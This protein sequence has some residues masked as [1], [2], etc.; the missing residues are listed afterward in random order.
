MEEGAMA[1]ELLP[2]ALWARIAPLLPPEPPKPKGGRPR[3][4]DRVA[5][6][7]ILFVLKT[8][9]PW[10]YLPAEM[11][12]GSGMTCWRRLRD[13]YQTGVWRR[14]APGASRRAGP[15]RWHR[16]GP[17]RAG[18]RRAVPAPGGQEPGKNPTDRG[19]QGTKRHLVVD[20]HGIPL[21]VLMSA[22]NVPD[23]KMMLATV[24]AIEPIRAKTRG[25]PRRRPHKLHA[26]KGYDYRHLRLALRKR[27]IIPRIARCGVEP[28]NRLGRYRWV[29]E[30]TLSWLNRFRRLKIRYE[31][32]ADI[33]LAF[34]QLGCALISLRFLG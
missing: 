5:L 23:S 16:L 21:A 17:G 15:G 33:H 9:I 3:V 22:A 26:D 7:G 24:D 2:D 1:K 10:E 6:T 28:K 14:A 11:G 18:L 12:C 27:R 25:R 31:H 20:A 34:L 32:R 4:S 30:R 29:V 8:G 13:W 19:K